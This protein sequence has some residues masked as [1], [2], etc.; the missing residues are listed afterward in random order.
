MGEQIDA[1]SD[2]YALA[3]V[4]YEM[5][6]GDAFTGGSVQAIV[7][8]IMTEAH[9]AARSATRCRPRGS[10]RAHGPRQAP[11]RSPRHGG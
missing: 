8:K 6:A 7:A 2:V 10:G 1:R 4:T 11:G 3:A 9:A 5:L